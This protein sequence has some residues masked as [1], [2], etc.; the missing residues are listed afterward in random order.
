MTAAEGLGVLPHDLQPPLTDVIAELE[1]MLSS[2]RKK[3]AA[4]LAYVVSIRRQA[5]GHV[6]EA[7]AYAQK[8]LALYEELPTDTIDQCAPTRVKIAGVSLPDYLHE[9]VI[10]SR[11]SHLL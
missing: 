7:S 4:E 2:G 3:E 5:E 1:Q 8:C 11:L 10:R 6:R 9:N